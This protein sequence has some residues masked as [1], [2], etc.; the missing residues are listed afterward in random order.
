MIPPISFITRNGTKFTFPIIEGGYSDLL[1]LTQPRAP[2][3]TDWADVDGL[4]AVKRP[5]DSAPTR[6]IKLPFAAN[7]AMVHT[8]IQNFTQLTFNGAEVRIQVTDVAEEQ[9]NRFYLYTLS[10]IIKQDRIPTAGQELY[11]YA[12]QGKQYTLTD[13]HTSL[14]DI[15]ATPLDGWH[16]AI[17]DKTHYKDTGRV[18]GR[19]CTIPILLRGDTTEQ[20]L[21]S[22]AALERLL[23]AQARNLLITP[24]GET[25]FYFTRSR[26]R[27]YALSVTP[28]IIYDL[29][30]TLL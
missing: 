1:Q 26:I 18:A 7:Y 30:I 6:P 29:T 20:L 28:Y 4:D 3:T 15:G 2:L 19:D 11:K 27:G 14:A 8:T 21:S 10:G 16:L 25:D 23:F 13:V 22:R 5:L 24:D 9:F 17:H 12:P